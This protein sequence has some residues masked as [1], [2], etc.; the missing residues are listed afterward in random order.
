MK[1]YVTNN[2]HQMIIES[3]SE[4]SRVSVWFDKDMG[5]LAYCHQDIH[6]ANSGYV[7]KEMMHEIY[8]ELVHCLMMEKQ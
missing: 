8:E 7:S 6:G 5:T 1:D 2:E 3:I 4:T